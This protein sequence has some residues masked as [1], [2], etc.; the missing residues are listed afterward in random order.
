MK[1]PVVTTGP[2]CSFPLPVGDGA[3]VGR[4]KICVMKINIVDLQIDS[5]QGEPNVSISSAM[6]VSQHDRLWHPSLTSLSL[7]IGKADSAYVYEGNS[8]LIAGMYDSASL[9]FME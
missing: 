1:G 7:V 3:G 4:C 8:F 5:M 6:K 9:S 2:F